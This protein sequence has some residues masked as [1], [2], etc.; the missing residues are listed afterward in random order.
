MILEA[1]HSPIV[2]P[3]TPSKWAFLYFSEMVALT[4]H[5][6]ERLVELLKAMKPGLT[7]IPE[8]EEE[9]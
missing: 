6:F 2:L 3:I 9:K 7:S 1:K 5:E 4:E 8:P